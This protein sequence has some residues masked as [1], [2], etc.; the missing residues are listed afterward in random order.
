MRKIGQ[1]TLQNIEI[2]VKRKSQLKWFCML[3]SRLWGFQNYIFNQFL[4]Y[5]VFF[6]KII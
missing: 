3:E 4:T 6:L 2:E 5:Y 1:L